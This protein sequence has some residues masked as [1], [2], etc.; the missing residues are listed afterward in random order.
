MRPKESDAIRPVSPLERARQTFGVVHI[1]SNYLGSELG[2][3]FCLFGIRVAGQNASREITRRVAQNCARQTAPLSAS[4]P[5][6]SND[7]LSRHEI[8]PLA[9]TGGMHI[10]PLFH[11]GPMRSSRLHLS[12]GPLASILF[13]AGDSEVIPESLLR[14]VEALLDFSPIHDIPPRAHVL[15]PA[16]LVFEVI[17]M[18]PN[19]KAQNRVLAF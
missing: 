12:A 3:L 1:G 14:G 13:A 4:S 7:L 17:G 10:N 19:V 9:R 6:D 2:K 18:L 8:P 15:D 5:Y 16:I 11:P